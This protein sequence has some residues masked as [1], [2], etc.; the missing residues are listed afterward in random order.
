MVDTVAAAEEEAAASF[1]GLGQ[2]DSFRPTLTAA[3]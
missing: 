3:V 2:L 1:S